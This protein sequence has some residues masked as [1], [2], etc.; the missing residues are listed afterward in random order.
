MFS[1]LVG[2][3][4]K[5]IIMTLVIRVVSAPKINIKPINK[6]ESNGCCQTFALI[7]GI[8]ELEKILGIVGF[9]TSPLKGLFVVF[10][11]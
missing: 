2:S 6:N 8:K 4:N 5:C 10:S 9:V 7:T 11:Q 3:V 1:F